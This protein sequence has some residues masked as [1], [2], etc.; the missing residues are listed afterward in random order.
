[1]GL[2]WIA[3]CRQSL[4]HDAWRWPVAEG[5]TMSA[6][7]MSRTT[8]R[9][10]AL[11]VVG[12]IGMALSCTENLPSGPDTFSASI[13]LVVPHDTTVVGDSS[14]AHAI[15]MDASGRVI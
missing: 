10:L 3:R 6:P 15:V 12:V 5:E 9:A 14:V 4:P 2:Q 1:M 8:R 13:R 7:R 11:S